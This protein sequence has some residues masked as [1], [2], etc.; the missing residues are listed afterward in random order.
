MNKPPG[1]ES[2]SART[3]TILSVSPSGAD[4]A[5]LCEILQ[6]A[7]SKMATNCRWIV[8]PVSTAASTKE[9]LAQGEIPIVI[10]ECDLSWGSWQT[11]LQMISLVAE[12]PLL[13]VAS[14]LADERLWAEALNLGAWDVL[15]K[16]FDADDVTRVVA[17]AW[18][19][20][21]ANWA[22]SRSPQ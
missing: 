9:A 14:R 19:H 13:I 18:R 6:D 2:S 8:H 4:H 15:A 20:R 17:S 21:Q 7:K 5:A 10:S 22:L 11:I 3:V 1:A 12:P 16:P